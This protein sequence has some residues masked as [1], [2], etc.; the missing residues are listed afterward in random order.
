M[1]QGARR[2]QKCTVGLIGEKIHA[3]WGQPPPVSVEWLRPPATQGLAT[4][5]SQGRLLKLQTLPTSDSYVLTSTAK[6][7]GHQFSGD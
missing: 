4:A 2:M 3:S 6:P 7:F 1:N 5:P